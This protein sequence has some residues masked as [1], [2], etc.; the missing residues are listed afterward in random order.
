MV[1]LARSQQKTRTMEPRT[2]TASP[3]QCITT[4]MVSCN[5]CTNQLWLS[6]ASLS[7]LITS[8]GSFRTPPQLV[9]K[10]YVKGFNDDEVTREVKLFWTSWTRIWQGR[11]HQ[12]AD[13]LHQVHWRQGGLYWKQTELNLNGFCLF[14]RLV[15]LW[16]LVKVLSK[17]KA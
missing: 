2:T 11:H 4:Q 6:T 15:T 7:S 17:Y 16:T 1:M 14:G 12:T 13:V 9:E 3:G 5:D 8:F 10:L